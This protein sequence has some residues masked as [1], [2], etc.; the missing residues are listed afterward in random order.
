MIFRVMA[1]I[2]TWSS[3]FI[4]AILLYH[5]SI[6]GIDRLS[7]DFLEN[8]PSRF[9]YKAVLNQHFMVVFGCLY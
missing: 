5:I 9:P 3:L 4:L 8:F 7:F 1:Q 6:S 2:T